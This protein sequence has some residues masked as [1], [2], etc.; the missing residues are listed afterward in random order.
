MKSAKILKDISVRATNFARGVHSRNPRQPRS[1]ATV[2][3]ATSKITF[4][5]EKYVWHSSKTG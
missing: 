3:L 4:V 1:V 2:V 5:H